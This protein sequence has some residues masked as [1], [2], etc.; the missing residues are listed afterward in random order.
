MTH[1]TLNRAVIYRQ[2][3]RRICSSRSRPSSAPASSSRRPRAPSC[4]S[5]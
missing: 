2:A 4:C 5:S 3:L 1:E